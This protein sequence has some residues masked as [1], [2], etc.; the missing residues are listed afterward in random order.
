MPESKLIASA[1]ATTL[2]AT[3]AACAALR[4]ARAA[5]ELEA[6]P[7]GGAAINAL[8]AARD[9]LASLEWALEIAQITY[10]E[11]ETLWEEQDD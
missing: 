2:C 4:S 10:D 6:A 7:N 8:T 5:T 3:R 9:S 1:K 11:A